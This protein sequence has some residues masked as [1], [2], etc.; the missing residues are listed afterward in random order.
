MPS[1]RPTRILDPAVAARLPP[2]QQ[3]VQKWPVLH[4]GSVPRVDLAAWRFR[5]NGLTHGETVLTWH[6]F[7][8]L[9]TS[10]LA[11]DFH[12]VTGWSRLD[13]QW[14]GVSVRDVVQLQPPLPAARFVIVY[15]M[16]GYSTNLPL[17]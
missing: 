4:Y 3:L 17:N 14:E 1:S 5:I 9:R 13:N 10:R 6:Q 12:C 8:A 16:N 2:N 11:A 7:S 15:G